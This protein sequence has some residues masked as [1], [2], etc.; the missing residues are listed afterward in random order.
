MDDA[1]AVGTVKQPDPGS[2][3][4]NSPMGVALCTPDGGLIAANRALGDLL[5][6]PPEQ[7]AGTTLSD[8]THPDDV[9][10]AMALLQGLR[11]SQGRARL[12]CRFLR[13]DGTEIPVQVT[14][15]WV[16]GSPDG[17]PPHLVTVVEDVTERKELEARLLHLSAHDPLTGLPNRL[18]FR[19]RL[20]HA[21][22]RGHREH[23]PTC[24]LVLDLDGFKAVNDQFGHPTGDA[25]L[26]AV[27]GRLTS[28]LRASDTA[29]RLGGDEFAVVC[30]NTER[31]DAEHL[32]A[33]LREALPGTLTVGSTTV[34]VGLSIGIGSVDGGTDPEQAQDTVVREADAAMYADK[35]R[36]R[37]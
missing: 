27:A 30:E 15:S 13:P 32:A 25:V 31:T 17:T 3:F 16:A 12:E 21:L 2:A 14:T 28:V 1:E 35:A 36:R 23:T 24:V 19:D 8:V 37:P 22:E 20:R 33:R 29:A 6:R 18:L 26:V 11:S 7:L 34:P 9:A 4:T 10:A 5:G